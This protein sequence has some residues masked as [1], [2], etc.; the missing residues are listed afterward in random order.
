VPKLFDRVK[1]NTAT[2]GTGDVTFG[3][4]TSPAFLTPAEA[5][6][7]DTD[8][9]RYV[10]VD[11]TDFEE[12]IGTIK[13]GVGEME[14]TTVT[15]S[16]I[17]GAVGT[18]KINLSGTA[19][20]AFTASAADIL[21]P[22]NNFSDVPDKPAALNTISGVSY[23]AVQSLSPAQMLQ[24]MQNVGILVGGQC[25]L[26]KNGSNLELQ[27]HRGKYIF[28]N[29]NLEEIPATPPSLA[30]VSV[31]ADNTYYI[32][33]Y[34]NAG[35]MALEAS[36]TAYATDAT[37]GH[38]IKSGDATR[39]LVG[40]ARTITGPAW[41]DTATQRFVISWFNKR[42]IAC[43]GGNDTQAGINSSFTERSTAGK[44]CEFLTWADESVHMR[45]DAALQTSGAAGTQLTASV[46]LDG[47]AAGQLQIANAAAATYYDNVSVSYFASLSEGYH[48][49]SFA[50]SVTAGSGTGRSRNFAEIM[51]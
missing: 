41:A 30:P 10:I 28:I 44:K 45:T 13:S 35:T 49:S 11:G 9:A 19:V 15:R 46:W 29:G 42:R 25:R 47:A 14:R 21:N 38:E 6:A 23:G 36:G 33:A 16:K 27:R 43:D 34:M 24:A 5:G 17:G 26:V 50:A 51:G 8:T 2:V 37:Y 20:L 4:A 18:S 40:M 22:D 31:S 48:I 1:V 3:A 7:I 12:G 39:A 32:Y